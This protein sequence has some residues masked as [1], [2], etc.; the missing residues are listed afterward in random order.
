[1]WKFILFPFCWIFNFLSVVCV[2]ICSCG[3]SRVSAMDSWWLGIGR[4]ME[5][6]YSNL[7]K[8][9]LFLVNRCFVGCQKYIKINIYWPLAFLKIL[10]CLSLKYY[11]EWVFYRRAISARSISCRCS[12][13]YFR[14]FGED[15]RNKSTRKRQFRHL[16]LFP[17]EFEVWAWRDS[18]FNLKVRNVCV[19]KVTGKF[20][21]LHCHGVIK[22]WIKQ[23]SR[24]AAN[25]WFVLPVVFLR[26]HLWRR[27]WGSR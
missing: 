26:R 7:L 12:L 8:A 27:R 9:G 16:L 15:D 3:L 23:I 21:S 13:S 5:I 10:T 25:Q 24:E 1:M 2:E 6:H 22:N 14:S 20:L 17:R 18:E 11:F 19:T 4:K